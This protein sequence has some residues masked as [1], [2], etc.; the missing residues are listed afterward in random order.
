MEIEISILSQICL[1]LFG[2]FIGHFISI[3]FVKKKDKENQSVTKD[4]KTND[5]S[6]ITNQKKTFF[7]LFKNTPMI[8]IKCL[9]ELTGCEIYAKCEYFLPFSSKD[10]MIKNIIETNIK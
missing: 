2:I 1:I 10:R 6:D 3:I 8:Y 7:D 5:K 9:S 4:D